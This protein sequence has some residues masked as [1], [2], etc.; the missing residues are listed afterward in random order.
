MPE[1]LNSL[2]TAFAAHIRDPQSQA[3]PADVEDRRMKIYRDLFFNN[4]NKFLSNNFPVLRQLYEDQDWRQ[5]VRDFYSEHRCKTPLFP[6]LPREFL[7]YIEEQRQDRPG[8]P[9]FMLELAHYEWVELALSMHEFD[10]HAVEVMRDGD[11]MQG[12]PVLSPLAWPLS[13]RYPVHKIRPG[14]T[15]SEPPEQASHILAYRNRSD[16]VKFMQLNDVSRLLLNLLQEDRG[17]SGFELL[18]EV[19]RRINHP[20]PDGLVENGQIL[21]RDL[22]D[23]EVLLGTRTAGN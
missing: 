19:A 16:K 12:V 8:D 20:H 9:P 10:L 7:R 3:A 1:S 6:E 13:Y 23:K 11:L 14:Y 2:Q 22:C 21:L 18:S 4:I 5:L 17:L 15:P